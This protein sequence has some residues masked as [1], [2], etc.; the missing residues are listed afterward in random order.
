[1]V[2]FMENVLRDSVLCPVPER[3][4][5]FE[6]QLAE[7]RGAP[8]NPT[9]SHFFKVGGVKL[10]YES[11]YSTE[12]TRVVSPSSTHPDGTEWIVYPGSK[13]FNPTKHYNVERAYERLL[14]VLYTP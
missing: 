6:L 7:H 14:L 9:S 12:P 8:V 2:Y 4:S 11:V 1:M 3:L 13:S 10:R 5:Q